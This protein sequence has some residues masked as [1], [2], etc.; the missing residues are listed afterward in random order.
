[1]RGN[2][3]Q[4]TVIA[5]RLLSGIRKRSTQRQE[6]DY[7]AYRWGWAMSGWCRAVSLFECHKDKFDLQGQSRVVSDSI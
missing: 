2:N 4:R 6:A 7:I 3:C 5:R 1:M